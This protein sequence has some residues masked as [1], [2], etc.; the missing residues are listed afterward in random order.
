MSKIQVPFKS[1]R[2]SDT[3]HED[4]YTFL[5][6]SG[7]IPLR[8]RNVSGRNYRGQYTHFMST[9]FFFFASLVVFEIMREIWC[10][11]SGH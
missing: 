6:I 9:N 4:K 11:Q 10:I 7:S 2:I 5:I 1:G 3:I 8:M